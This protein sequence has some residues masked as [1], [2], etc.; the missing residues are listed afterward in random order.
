MVKYVA[1]LNSIFDCHFVS[2][3]GRNSLTFLS[4]CRS[5]LWTGKVLGIPQVLQ[6]LVKYTAKRGSISFS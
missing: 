1:Y 5:T 3:V 4:F 6:E 2:M